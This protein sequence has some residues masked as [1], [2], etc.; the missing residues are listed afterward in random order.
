M[1][2]DYNDRET[3]TDERCDAAMDAYLPLMDN[4]AICDEIRDR[5]WAMVEAGK[6]DM[7]AAFVIAVE[8]L[9]IN[10]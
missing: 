5:Q 7:D 2:Y 6:A 9:V 8:E 10:A 4:S 3:F 1:T